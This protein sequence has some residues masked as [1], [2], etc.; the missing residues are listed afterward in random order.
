M[1]GGQDQKGKGQVTSAVVTV[2]K[3]PVLSVPLAI[4]PELT[5][6][7]QVTQHPQGVGK[8]I[9]TPSAMLT[10]KSGKMAV[11]LGHKGCWL[12]RIGTHR[13]NNV[14][15]KTSLLARPASSLWHTACYSNW[16]VS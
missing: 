9:F 7:R 16:S 10:L 3:W 6:T 4:N 11:C 15:Q 14:G 2:C 13:M 5:L 8:S 1:S 12:F